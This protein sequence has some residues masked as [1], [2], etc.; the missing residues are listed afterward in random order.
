MEQANTQTHT[1]TITV[2][3]NYQLEYNWTIVI[4]QDQHVQGRL[5]YYS[6]PETDQSWRRSGGFEMRPERV[7]GKKAGLSLS[8]DTFWL[9]PFINNV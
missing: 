8:T 4:A 3:I 2:N 9:R 7:D 1:I 5:P 6:P